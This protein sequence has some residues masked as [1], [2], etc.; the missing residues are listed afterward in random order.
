LIHGI[1][2]LFGYDHEKSSAEAEQMFRKT[3]DLLAQLDAW[4]KH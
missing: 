3:E 1:L 2:H 4:P